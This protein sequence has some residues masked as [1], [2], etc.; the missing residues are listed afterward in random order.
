MEGVLYINYNG[1]EYK[2]DHAEP[3]MLDGWGIMLD[4]INPLTS[5][6]TYIVYK[7]P[8][9]ISGSVYYKPGRSGKGHLIYL[10]NITSRN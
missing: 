7:I 5:K 8:K 3:V 4:Q 2:F 6:T 1:K 10:G 9:E